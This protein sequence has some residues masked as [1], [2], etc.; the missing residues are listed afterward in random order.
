MAVT[1]LAHTGLRRGE[2]AALRWADID[3]DEKTIRVLATV[4][5]TKVDGVHLGPPKSATPARGIYVEDRVVAA[6]R[7][8]RN[9]QTEAGLAAGLALSPQWFVFSDGDPMR[10]QDPCTIAWRF[11]LALAKTKYKG[12]SL[13]DLRHAHGSLLY[14]SGANPAATAARLG[15]TLA[16]FLATYTHETEEDRRALGELLCR[17]CKKLHGSRCWQQPDR[18]AVDD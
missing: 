18:Y 8:E 5:R 14:E 16:V 3:L 9:R 12:R 17:R 11:T 4:R 13:H 7:Q 6:L 1:V 15:H 2:P 10:P